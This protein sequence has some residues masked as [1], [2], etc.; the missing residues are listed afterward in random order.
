ML[1]TPT[2]EF[3]GIRLRNPIP[4][5]KRS[6]DNLASPA[7]GP[8]NSTHSVWTALERETSADFQLIRATTDASLT[9]AI[10]HI[11]CF[12]SQRTKYTTND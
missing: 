2:N 12:G 7:A 6:V 3:P 4:H 1:D 10:H 5:I 11:W 8:L 9:A